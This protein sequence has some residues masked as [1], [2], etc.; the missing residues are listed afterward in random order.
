MYLESN[1]LNYAQEELVL[2]LKIYPKHEEG[3]QMMA[4]IL[5]QQCKQKNQFCQEASEYKIYLSQ[6]YKTTK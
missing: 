2:F 6:T 3:I 5:D 4:N 1:A